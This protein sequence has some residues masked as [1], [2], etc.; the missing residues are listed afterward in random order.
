MTHVV[1]PLEQPRGSSIQHFFRPAASSAARARV[2]SPGLRVVITRDL[3]GAAGFPG[4][5]AASRII[6]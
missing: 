6:V 2:S 4:P 3:G 1:L 5:A